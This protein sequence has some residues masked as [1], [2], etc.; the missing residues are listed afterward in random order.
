MQA[1]PISGHPNFSYDVRPL[2]GMQSEVIVYHF[3]KCVGDTI[4][5]DGEFTIH[6]AL[7][8]VDGV[9]KEIKANEAGL[10]KV[11]KVDYKELDVFR[12]RL[13]KDMLTYTITITQHS[14]ERNGVYTAFF[15]SP[16]YQF[17]IDTYL[18]PADWTRTTGI[19]TVTVFKSYKQVDSGILAVSEDALK[20]A[21]LLITKHK[22]N[23]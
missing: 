21:R 10:H 19:S 12:V 18:P 9:I 15:D 17:K 16:D 13:E 20:L 4:I 11:I 6:A 2:D 1:F 14:D 7:R 23:T 22:A 5:A 3:R 8:I